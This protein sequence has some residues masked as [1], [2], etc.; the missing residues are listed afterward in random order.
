MSQNEE[1]QK[2]LPYSCKIEADQLYKYSV[3]LE[4]TQKCVNSTVH[5]YSDNIITAKT[6][7]ISLLKETMDALRKDG[8]RTGPLEELK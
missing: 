3:K 2:L 8:F 5:V 1:L 6:E 7:A 4:T